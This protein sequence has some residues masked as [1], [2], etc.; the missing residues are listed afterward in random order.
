MERVFDMS[1]RQFLGCT[2]ISPK[3]GAAGMRA[4]GRAAPTFEEPETRVQFPKEALCY[5]RQHKPPP[6]M[7]NTSKVHL[8]SEAGPLVVLVGS[9]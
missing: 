4:R 7:L 5:M 8:P 9:E 1:V 3:E 2:L 6:P